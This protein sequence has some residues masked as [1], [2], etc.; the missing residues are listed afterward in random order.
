MAIDLNSLTGQQRKIVRDA[1]LAAYT[2]ATLEMM[3]DVEL[4]KRLDDVAAAANFQIQVFNLVKEAQRQAWIDNLVVAAE[5]DSNNPRIKNLRRTLETSADIRLDD[6]EASVAQKAPAGAGLERLV[7]EDGGFI[8]WGL[9]VARFTDIGRQI[10]RI[11][12]PSGVNL[13]GGTGFLVAPN[14][15]LTNYHVVE[16]VHSGK[17]DP[18]KMVCRFDFVLSGPPATAVPLAGDWLVDHSRY[19]PHDAGDRGGL[20]DP[21]HLDYALL[22]LDRPLGQQ[23]PAGE[24]GP[25]GWIEVD[26]ATPPP[27]AAS[28]VFIGQHPKL[29]PLKLAVGAALGTNGNAT[30]LRYDANT[31]R[32]SS[33]SPVFNVGLRLVA[34]HHGGDPDYS[35]LMGD[36]N[37]GIPIA[38]IVQRMVDRDVTPFWS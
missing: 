4:D 15:V 21:D 30:R 25:R 34:L 29:D 20:P 28:I 27:A 19:S 36:F 13:G 31:E 23:T 24:D 5:R 2:H 6:V 35:K 9:W 26:A 3:L 1:L 14:L 37:Q 8:D 12:Y 22:Q 10:C 7:R 33:G 38:H 16:P 18:L 11:E 17:I 32:G